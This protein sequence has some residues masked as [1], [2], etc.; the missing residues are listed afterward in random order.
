MKIS[1]KSILWC[2]GLLGFGNTSNAQP[3]L[4]SSSGL[5]YASVGAVVQVNGGMMLEGSSKVENEGTLI[6]AS[7]SNPG[8]LSM[9]GSSFVIGNGIYKIEQDWLNNAV[10]TANS[11]TVELYGNTQQFIGGSVKTVFHNLLLTGSGSGQNRKK[12]LLS[13]NAVVSLS[14]TLM[15]NDRET[16]TNTF[17]IENPDPSSV[18]NNTSAGSEG[19][20]SSLKSG[21]F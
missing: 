4:N 18:L 6:I 19:F 16:D 2:F 3:T 14:G 1:A 15:L 7:K 5:I 10:F 8:T 17:F 21:T 11:S 20:V 13:I 9:K 12:S